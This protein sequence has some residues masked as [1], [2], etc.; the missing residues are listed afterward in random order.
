MPQALELAR[1]ITKDY[2]TQQIIDLIRIQISEGATIECI[3]GLMECLRI[4]SS[5]KMDLD[6]L[7]ECLDEMGAVASNYRSVCLVLMAQL[8]L[9]VSCNREQA[10]QLLSK[11]NPLKLQKIPPVFIVRCYLLKSATTDSSDLTQKDKMLCKGL[12]HF[13]R[14]K[15][16][17]S[18]DQRIRLG[19][20]LRFQR[21]RVLLEEQKYTECLSL[22]IDILESYSENPGYFAQ[23]SMFENNLHN[24]VSLLLYVPYCSA[25]VN[26]LKRFADFIGCDCNS[27]QAGSNQAL[28]QA[29]H[30]WLDAHLTSDGLKTLLCKL[31][32][33]QIVRLDVEGLMECLR[34]LF[35]DE[36]KFQQV[37]RNILEAD[38]V[39]ISKKFSNVKLELMKQL[40]GLTN[41]NHENCLEDD[42]RL[43]NV[44]VELILDRKINA[45]LDEVEKVVYFSERLQPEWKS[46]VADMLVSVDKVYERINAEAD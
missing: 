42:D 33:G 31:T 7:Y 20:K 44:I 45:K 8:A 37:Y 40:I 12:A 30:Q 34:T 16:A 29:L 22:S 28:H 32:R 39:S 38:V 27:S 46:R 14:C 19:F 26:S 21:C 18:E 15:D 43:F 9:E 11:V 35:A 5:S 23:S 36:E 17:M 41:V 13:N 25:K 6:P 10:R 1:N 4:R 2:S 3:C 24:V